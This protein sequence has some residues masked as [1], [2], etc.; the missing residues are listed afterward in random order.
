MP[1]S[2]TLKKCCCRRLHCQTIRKTYRFF[3]T[4]KSKAAVEF[5]RIDSLWS[6]VIAG[7]KIFRSATYKCRDSLVRR[8]PDRHTATGR[9]RDA[10]HLYACRLHVGL[11]I[12]SHDGLLVPSAAL[13]PHVTHTATVCQETSFQGTCSSQRKDAGGSGFK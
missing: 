11:T 13:H 2:E 4:K 6:L 3:Q 5:S 12:A 10:F 1:C 9:M 8:N 7:K